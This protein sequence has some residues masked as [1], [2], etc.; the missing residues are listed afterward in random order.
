MRL[1][2]IAISVAIAASPFLVPQ[3]SNAAPPVANR[4]ASPIPNAYISGYA[5]GTD[6]GGWADKKYRWIKWQTY[7]AG[8]VGVRWLTTASSPKLCRTANSRGKINVSRALV[9]WPYG[10]FP[11]HQAGS[12]GQLKVHPLTGG[13]P[14]GWRCFGAPSQWALNAQYMA[15]TAGQSL[16]GNSGAFGA[17]QGLAN[18]FGFCVSG[19]ARLGEDKKWH[20]GAWIA[21][22]P[23]ALKCQLRLKLRGTPDPNGGTDTYPSFDQ[24]RTGN[25][26]GFYNAT[27]C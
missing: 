7:A 8:T 1:P 23:S 16:S 25:P 14:K 9:N 18:E 19:K 17:A 24:V 13:V 21:W 3:I 27:A 22:G 2:A 12:G 20:G 15:N 6:C 5:G 4:A 26:A 10:P 11:M